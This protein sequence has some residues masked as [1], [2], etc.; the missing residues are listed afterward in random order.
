MIPAIFL[1]ILTLAGA[2]AAR[3]MLRVR[4]AVSR[5]PK[6]QGRVLEREVVPATASKTGPGFYR[7]Q[8]RV[9]Y[10]YTVDGV[11]Y[12]SERIRYPQPP[13]HSKQSSQRF[14]DAI[15]PEVTVLYDPAKPA[16]SWLFLPLAWH[17]A[18]LVSVCVLMG[19]VALL[20]LCVVALT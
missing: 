17:I 12:T 6:T 1:I 10:T 18:V 11:A 5:W 2:F 14:L 20:I 13:V 16:D 19:L 15:P 7:W 3:G 8:P 9:K 4:S